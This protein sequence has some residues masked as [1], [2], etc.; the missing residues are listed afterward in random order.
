MTT[1]GAGRPAMPSADELNRKA[2]AA[3]G[4]WGLEGSMSELETLMWRSE[5]H[6]ELSS[7]IVAVMLL[8]TVPEWDRL[9]AAHEWAVNL[10]RRTRERVQEPI[11]P[12][13]PPV[14]VEDEKFKLAN[15][16]RRAQL[17]TPTDHGDDRAGLLAYAERFALAPLNRRR[18][19]WEAVLVEGL[20]D[21]KAA[22][23]LKLH[24]SVTDGLGGIQLLSLVQS[25]TREHTAD[26]PASRAGS[27][28]GPVNP[29]VLATR[30]LASRVG[31]A[32][33]MLLRSLKF[34]GTVLSDPLQAGEE[35]VRFSA[36][37]RRMLPPPPAS[38]SPLFKGRKGR[39]W[40]FATLECEF[41]RLRAAA[42]AASGSVNDAYIAA[43]LGGLRRYHE[44]HGTPVENLPMA[45]PVSLRRGD[46]PM[47][48]NKFA[49]ALLAG[50][51]GVSDPVERIA[52]IR[53]TV[54][55]LRTE[56]ALDSFGLFA[57]MV[58]LLPSA[59]GAAA[60][61]LG[62]AADMSASNVPGLPFESYLAGAKVERVFAFGPLP[63]VAIMVAMTTH[64]GACCIG[65]NVDGD[66]VEDLSVL[67]E[68]FQEGLDEVLAIAD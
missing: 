12:V 20:A 37:L 55:T 54:L 61:R 6:P 23:L 13:G 35:A 57:P 26:K 32:P 53:G 18:P 31:Q 17:D 34:G 60:W 3:A 11:V 43:L 58:N 9:W 45:M 29:A 8:D 7:T 24:H 28:P 49:G 2:W 36:S 67:M 59:V 39:N 15:H 44:R 27:S 10:I 1:G 56:P 33:D 46:D 62:S 25:R 65:F 66:A 41:K 50:P 64:A 52:V 68:C 42:K 63:G 4:Q 5:R 21:G 47:G 16:L 48:G 22:Y 19:L 38:P 30:Q 14:W 40:R 51:V